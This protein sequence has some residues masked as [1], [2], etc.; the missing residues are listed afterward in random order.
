M[1]VVQRDVEGVVDDGV[2]TLDADVGADRVRNAEQQQRLIEEVRAD[3]E[4]HSGS[5]QRFLAPGVRLPLGTES[6]EMRFEQHDVAERT[7]RHHLLDG[8]EIASVAAILVHGDDALLFL[9]DLDQILC[10]GEGRRE[11]FVDDDVTAGEQ[12][13]LGDRMMGRVRRR[14]HDE[15]DLACQQL[16]NASDEFHI[17]IALVGGTMPLHNRGKEQAVHR[18]NN[19]RVEHLP[20]ETKT[21]EADVERR[22]QPFGCGTIR[23]YGLGAFQPLGYTFFASS[24]ETEPAMMT[25]SPCFQLTGVETLCFAVNCNESITRSTSSKLRPVVIGETMMSV[26]FLSGPMTKTL[27]TV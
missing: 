1:R 9:G 5:R 16:V 19:R 17:R 27:R 18:A 25:S 26:I 22:R 7:F 20:G 10:V 12:T 3:I 13:L 23:R 2:R 11:R 24:S 6:V 21:D 4:P 14:D 8:R 15:I